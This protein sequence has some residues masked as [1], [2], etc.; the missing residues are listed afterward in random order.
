M[1][2]KYIVAI[3]A[4]TAVITTLAMLPLLV[5]AKKV[6]DPEIKIITI[7]VEKPHL[8]PAQIIWLARLMQCESGLKANAVNPKDLDNTPSYGLLQ[9]KPGTF[10]AAV[11]EFGLSTTTSYMDP[12]V[13]VA[14][15]EQW[16]LRGGV[17]W[18]H[19]FPGCTTKLGLPPL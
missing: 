10:N 12:E 3:A 5:K 13:Q 1:T 2:T 15:V 17:N 11:K 18:R 6:P 14:I 9:F 19:Q 7:E 16:I 4:L 8:S